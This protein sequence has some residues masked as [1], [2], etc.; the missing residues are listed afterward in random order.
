MQRLTLSAVWM[1]ETSIRRGVTWPM[2]QNCRASWVWTRGPK[3][4]QWGQHTDHR[5][6]AS[7]EEQRAAEGGDEAKACS[8]QRWKQL[9]PQK[10]AFSGS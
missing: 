9:C 8:E 5:R 2:G 10:L 3:D 7:Q 4:Y 1:E 6:T